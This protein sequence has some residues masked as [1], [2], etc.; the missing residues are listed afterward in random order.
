[1]NL[2]CGLEPGQKVSGVLGQ[3]VR[4]AVGNHIVE[5]SDQEHIQINLCFSKK[6]TL[7]TVPQEE[8]LGGEVQAEM[9][10][11]NKAVGVQWGESWIWVFITWNPQLNTG[12]WG[13]GG[14]ERQ[15]KEVNVFR[16]LAWLTEAGNPRN[17]QV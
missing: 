3:G 4:H 12:Y 16:F 7:V 1:M 5:I 8:Q 6:I 14:K 11:F 9:M 13:E 15:G 10:G 2:E 17:Q